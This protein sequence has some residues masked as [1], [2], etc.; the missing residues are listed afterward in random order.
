MNKF[1]FSKKSLERLKKANPVLQ[2]VFYR[3][4][5][6]SDIDFGIVCTERTIEEQKELYKNGRSK[7]DGVTKLSKH[8]IAPAEAGDLMVFING[9]VSW[10]SHYYIYLGGLFKSVCAELG[11]QGRW[12]GNFDMDTDILEQDFDDIGHFEIIDKRFI[13]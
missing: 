5:E 7:I 12:G 1:K 4:L 8:N 6:I 2:L 10:E 3:M 11:V 9:Q 13:K